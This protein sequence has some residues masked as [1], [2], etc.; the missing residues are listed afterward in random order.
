MKLDIGCGKRPKGDV[1][2]DLFIEETFH[3]AY[4]GNITKRVK[5]LICCDAQHLPFKNNTFE[6]VIADHVIE[7]VENPFLMLKEMVRVTSHKIEILTPHRF[8][9]KDN[10]SH[11]HGF[12]RT[13]FIRALNDF[14]VTNVFTQYS[15]F[16]GFPHIFMGLFNLPSEIMVEAWKD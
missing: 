9:A 5:N 4:K 6:T 8:F 2:T 13:W 15:R 12:T 7:H 16:S 11:K 3:R 10:P 14:G 1:N